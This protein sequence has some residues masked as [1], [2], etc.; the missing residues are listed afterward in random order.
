MTRTGTTLD[1]DRKTEGSCVCMC[2]VQCR[3]IVGNNCE[4]QHSSS[5]GD[6]NFDARLV[7]KTRK[8]QQTNISEIRQDD[9]RYNVINFSLVDAPTDRTVYKTGTTHVFNTSTCLKTMSSTDD[10]HAIHYER[11]PDTLSTCKTHE[12]S[13]DWQRRAAKNPAD[14]KT[15]NSAKHDTRHKQ[16]RTVSRR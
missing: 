6:C 12:I 14:T 15:M 10:Q 9:L 13:S 7:R 4:F 11:M 3:D 5:R 8:Y 16:F 2:T 1:Q